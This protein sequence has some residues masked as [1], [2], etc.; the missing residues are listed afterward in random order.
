MSS[1]KKQIGCVNKEWNIFNYS[2]FI[3]LPVSN[4]AKYTKWL[5][6]YFWDLKKI[7][8]ELR[9]LEILSQLR[10]CVTLQTQSSC[11]FSSF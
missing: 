5:L 6:S 1:I 10:H 4:P 7:A 3:L 9:R 8:W 2:F 11:Y